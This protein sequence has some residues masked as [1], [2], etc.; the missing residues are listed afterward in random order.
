MRTQKQT[1]ISVKLS[2]ELYLK[3]RNI[4]QIFQSFE[5]GC[6]CED[7]SVIEHQIESGL[8]NPK[9]TFLLFKVTKVCFDDI[10]ENT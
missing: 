8:L 3:S 5:L 4:L 10:T 9:T 2:S 6:I 1:N 7:K